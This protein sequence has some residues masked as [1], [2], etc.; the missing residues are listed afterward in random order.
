[1]SVSFNLLYLTYLNVIRSV[2]KLNLKKSIKEIKLISKMECKTHF[3]EG[4]SRLRF[5]N[6]PLKWPINLFIFYT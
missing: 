1:M 5:S 4:N 3:R 2:K 6:R